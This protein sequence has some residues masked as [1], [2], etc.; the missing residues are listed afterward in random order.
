V[1]LR[2]LTGGATCAVTGDA[3]EVLAQLID[4]VESLQEWD[5]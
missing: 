4:P 3:A 2:F 1:T 5:A